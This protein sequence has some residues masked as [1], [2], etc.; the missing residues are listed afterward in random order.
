MNL[1]ANQDGV[2][3]IIAFLVVA[4]IA[5]VGF[6]G[7]R[8]V[9]GNQSKDTTATTAVVTKTPSAIKNA[10]D[11]EQATASLNATKIDSGVDASQ[12]D[13]DLNNLL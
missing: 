1:R 6:A 13:Q 11:V 2:G 7:Y 9:A 3:H 5:V 4:V 8:V 10:A 12:L